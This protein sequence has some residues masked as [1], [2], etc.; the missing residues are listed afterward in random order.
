MLNRINAKQIDKFF[1]ILIACLFLIQ[2]IGTARAEGLFLGPQAGFLPAPGE[3]VFLSHG[4]DSPVF[5]G[6][7]VDPHDPFHLE[8]ILDPGD[9]NHPTEQLKDESNVLIRYF[10]A[11]LTIPA[12]DLWVNLSPY[13]KNR[14]VTSEFGQTEMGRDLLA[15][16]YLLKQITASAIDPEGEIGKKFWAKVYQLSFDKYGTT[17]IPIDTFNKVWIVPDKAVVLEAGDKAIVSES[18]LK[19]MLESDY[20]ALDNAVI[21]TTDSQGISSTQETQEFGKKVIRDIVIPEL[22]REVNEGKNFSRLRQVYQSLILA[23]WFKRKIKDGILHKAYVDQKKVV[24]LNIDDA[25]MSEKIWSQYVQAFQKGVYNYIKEEV[26]PL[27]REVIPRKYFS[28]GVVLDME[29]AMVTRPIGSQNVGSILSP[30]FRRFASWMI[31]TANLL[32]LTPETSA[33]AG[34]EIS[35]APVGAVS[36][37]AV[38][39]QEEQAAQLLLAP[40]TTWK[41]K[42]YVLYG[43]KENK[44]SWWENDK[45]K[46]AVKAMLFDHGVRV[47]T[48]AWTLF[49]KHRDLL[50][51]QDLDSMVQAFS[52]GGKD[53]L[54]GDAMIWLSELLSDKTLG[55]RLVGD[56]DEYIKTRVWPEF[57]KALK[58]APKG[59]ALGMYSRWLIEWKYFSSGSKVVLTDQ[60]ADII[61]YALRCRLDPEEI[62]SIFNR[63][64]DKE[65]SSF[66]LEMFIVMALRANEFG[67][68]RAS[69]DAV[70]HLYEMSGFLAKTPGLGGTQRLAVAFEAHRLLFEQNVPI[71]DENTLRSV[72]YVLETR[73]V[74]EQA[75]VFQ[76]HVIAFFHRQFL[77][78]DEPRLRELV[79]IANVGEYKLALSTKEAFL[80]VLRTAKDTTIY[81]SGH[82][83]EK[84]VLILDPDVEVT[85]A[86]LW[87]A[88]GENPH[89]QTLN[90][91]LDACYSGSIIALGK[92]SSAARDII[93]TS[94]PNTMSGDAKGGFLP[95]VL[96]QAR[97]EHTVTFGIIQKAGDKLQ[98]QM[99]TFFFLKDQ[100]HFKEFLNGAFVPAAQPSKEED[101]G[102]S[103]QWAAGLFFSID[104]RSGFVTYTGAFPGGVNSKV[105]KQ[106][107]VGGID[108]ASTEYALDVEATGTGT[109]LD[110]DPAALGNL[111]GLQPVIVGIAPFDLDAFMG[112]STA[113]HKK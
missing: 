16:D 83:T 87:K 33:Y 44:V 47:R 99:P 84:G 71:T 111:Q 106:S 73:R 24:G 9:A 108:L 6:I 23:F 78:G 97:Q 19:V 81:F 43:L 1:R 103:R 10:L 113:T 34:S 105:D 80:D 76:N 49:E 27:M 62:L 101:F 52:R 11:A 107:N 28:G 35:T 68:G 112:F 92:G 29:S 110:I 64:V 90:L 48:A 54:D 51:R 58:T 86:E 102:T 18:R 57:V 4:F 66:K 82:G 67:G 3:H 14:I 21:R 20:V 22:E 13:E 75:P 60:D 15:Q 89:S 42:I 41:G 94:S 7:K 31:L 32:T 88:L 70:R 109:P 100:G 93:T 77:K 17:D 69:M 8:F 26:D 98:E 53:L 74:H 95:A 38:K 72:D 56:R 2:S 39:S 104:L 96:D 36:V 45:L 85:A 59:S 91:I 50:T 30:R 79:R 5:R 40:E 65:K 61:F 25:K 55:D 46:N 12:K 63:K 37:E